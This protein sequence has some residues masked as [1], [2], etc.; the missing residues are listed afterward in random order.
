MENFPLFCGLNGYSLVKQRK[1]RVYMSKE[2]QINSGMAHNM[3]S[4]GTKIVGTI[5][6]NSDIRIDCEIEGDIVSKGKVVVGTLGVIKG[7]VDCLNA[8]VMGNIT[9]QIK[10]KELLSVKATAKI[11]GDIITKILAIE[12]KALFNGTCKMGETA[13]AQQPAVK[14]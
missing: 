9:G 2:Q 11:T 12:Q 8:E 10:V 5:T 1:T 6:T 14:K 13:D 7:T 3:L 4:A